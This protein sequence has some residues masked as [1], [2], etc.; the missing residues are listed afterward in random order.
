MLNNNRLDADTTAFLVNDMINGT[1]RT[2]DQ[3]RDDAIAQSGIIGATA[4]AVAGLRQAS[5]P[6]LWI[7]IERRADRSDVANNIVDRYPR[8]FRLP[9]WVAGSYESAQVEELPVH[10]DDQVILKPRMDP[11]VATDLDIQLRARNTKTILLCGYS[12]NGGVESCARTAYCLGYDVVVMSD[13][14]FNVDQE[15]HDYSLERILPWYSRV[16]TSAEVLEMLNRS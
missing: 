2:G 11:F 1:L 7:R 14:C 16:R 15:L 12:T 13:C 5:V 3:E 9:P 6:I 10:K 8:G 4:D